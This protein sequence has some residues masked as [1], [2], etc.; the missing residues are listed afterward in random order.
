MIYPRKSDLTRWTL[1]PWSVLKFLF[2]RF[3]FL[4]FLFFC[5]RPRLIHPRTIHECPERGR[6]VFLSR[7]SWDGNSLNNTIYPSSYRVTISLGLLWIH[8]IRNSILFCGSVAA[9][10]ANWNVWPEYLERCGWSEMY[11]LAYPQWRIIPYQILIERK[12]KKNCKTLH[13]K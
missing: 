12:K 9:G 3:S 5:Y 4:S 1:A 7:P 13:R 11:H 10:P 8:R 6:A 2:L